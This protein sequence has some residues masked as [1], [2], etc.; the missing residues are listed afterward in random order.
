MAKPFLPS[1]RSSNR[2]PVP[3]HAQFSQSYIIIWCPQLLNSISS[4]FISTSILPSKSFQTLN[5]I[6]DILDRESSVT[7][8]VPMKIIIDVFSWRT[9]LG[10]R[11]EEFCKTCKNVWKCMWAYVNFSKEVLAFTKILKGICHI[12]WWLSSLP[13]SIL[14]F[15]FSWEWKCQNKDSITQLPLQHAMNRWTCY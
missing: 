14:P 6:S 5:S 13:I 7:M 2:Q 15:I 9:W 1:V 11:G 12:E 8:V 10:S 3:L 4:P